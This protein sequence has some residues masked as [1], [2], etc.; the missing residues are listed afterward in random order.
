MKTYQP[1][2]KEVSREWHLIDAEGEVL[3]RLSARVAG[4]LMGKHKPG[5][6]RHMDVGDW[7]VILNAEKIEV[8][9]RKSEQKVYYSHSGYPGGFKKVAYKKLHEEHPERV[10]EL[11]V[12]GMLPDN[13][14]RR[15][16]LA[17]LKLVVGGENPYEGK[18]RKENKDGEEKK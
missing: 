2:Q 8:S 12:K 11:A 16:R 13:R 9:G 3:G 10:I 18:F 5:Y 15:D 6:S 7:V 14:L 17:R 1:K 4:L